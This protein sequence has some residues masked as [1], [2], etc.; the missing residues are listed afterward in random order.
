MTSSPK[1]S[2]S[3]DIGSAQLPLFYKNVAVLDEKR[4]GKKRLSEGSFPFAAEA[5]A[6]PL[7]GIE[8]RF[9]VT[10]YPIVFFNEAPFMPAVIVGLTKDK[11][12]L[13]NGDGKWEEG[14]YVPAYVRRYPFIFLESEDKE[15]LTLCIDEDSETL[16][17][18]GDV[19]LFDGDQPSE[20]TNRILEF[21]R[22]FQGHYN[23]TLEFSKALGEQELLIEKT[24]DAKTKDGGQHVLGGFKVVDENK[25]RE[26]PDNLASKWHNNGW[27]PLIYWHIASQ[28]NW[29]RLIDRQAIRS[30]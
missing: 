20:D 22:V 1:K 21:C 6:I 23:N 12:L 9:A 16:D 2:G 19:Q 3:K 7:N 15:T 28:N 11:N 27:L 8:F 25:M 24:A 14:C 17:K 18:E 5:N 13:I 26:F 29:G 4:H 30:A 10:E